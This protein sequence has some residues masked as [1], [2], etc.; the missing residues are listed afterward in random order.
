MSAPTE[1]TPPR[2]TAGQVRA[3]AGGGSRLRGTWTTFR[4][5]RS[6]LVGLGVLSFF[7]LVAVFAPLLAD[8]RAWR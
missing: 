2:G 5:H 8:L 3:G 1:R 6:G 7:I 4:R